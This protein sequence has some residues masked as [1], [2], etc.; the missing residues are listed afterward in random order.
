MVAMRP[1]RLWCGA[2]AAALV[3]AGSGCSGKGPVKVNGSVTLDGKPL[4]NATVTFIPEQGAGRNATGT[5]DQSGNFRL[6]TL[7]PD[8]GAMPGDYKVTVQQVEGAEAPPAADMKTAMEG[9]QKAVA[10]FKP[11]ASIIPAK[12]SDPGKTT[13]RQKVPAEGSVKLDLTSK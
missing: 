3:L 8:D 12:Y 13:L 4:S 5:T 2:L 1:R 10:K 6:T 11:K 7:K 9:Y